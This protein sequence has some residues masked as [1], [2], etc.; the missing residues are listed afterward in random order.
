VARHAATESDL[1]HS[2]TACHRGLPFLR[3]CAPALHHPPAYPTLPYD[4]SP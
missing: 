1:L 3:T 4:H 2:N